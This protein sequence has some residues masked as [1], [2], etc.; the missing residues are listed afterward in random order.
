[1]LSCVSDLFGA[2]AASAIRSDWARFGGSVAAALPVTCFESVLFVRSLLLVESWLSVRYDLPDCA[3][4]SVFSPVASLYVICVA[5][6]AFEV[7]DAAVLSFAS[8]ISVLFDPYSPLIPSLILFGFN[9]SDAAAWSAVSLIITL[10][11]ISI[12]SVVFEVA[13]SVT[14]SVPA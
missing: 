3:V 8:W 1:V 14:R 10:S 6:V 12:S 7:S 9:T 13:L 2:S 4:L 5:S 11:V